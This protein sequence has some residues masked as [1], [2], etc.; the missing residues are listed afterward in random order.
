MSTAFDMP[1]PVGN[2]ALIQPV[3]QE[4]QQIR[5]NY[6]VHQYSDENEQVKRREQLR[7]ETILAQMSGV[8]FGNKTRINY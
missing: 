4:F 7:S 8:L 3:A 1:S 5:G 2:T 6:Q